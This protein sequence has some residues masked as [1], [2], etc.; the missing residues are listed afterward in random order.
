MSWDDIGYVMSS[1]YRVEVMNHLSEGAKT[2]SAIAESTDIPIAHVS[3]ALSN[4]RDRGLVE[5]LVPE[6]RKK[7]RFYGL[8]EEGEDVWEEVESQGITTQ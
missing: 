5:L 4:L 1:Q 8:T 3:R 7:G 2:P 6:E